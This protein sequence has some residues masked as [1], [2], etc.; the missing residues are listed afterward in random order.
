MQF[1]VT[2]I[3]LEGYEVP[4]ELVICRLDIVL[5]ASVVTDG[6]MQ[7]I[8]MSSCC[9]LACLYFHAVTKAQKPSK[10]LYKF[11][12]YLRLC[13]KIAKLSILL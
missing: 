12:S 9:Y 13:V 4:P 7:V 2:S 3:V 11:S 5:L 10:L 8:R 1:W 6:D